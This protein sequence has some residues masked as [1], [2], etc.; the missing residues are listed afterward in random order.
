MCVCL[1][2]EL[3]M[4]ELKLEN[5]SLGLI[6]I[7]GVNVPGGSLDKQHWRLLLVQCPHYFF[8]LILNFLKT[9]LKP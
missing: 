6:K 5:S 4:A 8:V 9:I 2:D 1:P 7:G 3:I